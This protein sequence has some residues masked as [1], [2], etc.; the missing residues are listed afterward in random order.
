MY[1]DA[2]CYNEPT[3]DSHEDGYFVYGEGY[4]FFL[5]LGSGRTKIEAWKEA[6]DFVNNR[7][8]NMLAS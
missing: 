3:D 1:P 7:A 6:A 2:V 4:A 8:I 5:Y